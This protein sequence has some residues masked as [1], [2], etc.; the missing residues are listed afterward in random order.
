MG[1][2]K[3]NSVVKEL[4]ELSIWPDGLRA[5]PKKGLLN[6]K[7]K[8]KKIVYDPIFISMD[9]RHLR[10]IILHE[11]AHRKMPQYALPTVFSISTAL[12]FVTFVFNFI[13]PLVK[14]ALVLV[15]FLLMFKFF[16]KHLQQ[17]EYNADLWA[18]WHYRKYYGGKASPV[19]GRSLKE[20]EM[21][22][23]EHLEEN[24]LLKLKH[25]IKKK[26]IRLDIHPSIEERVGFVKKYLEE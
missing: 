17:D 4:K 12:F 16:K 15:L 23:D 26:V 3:I 7:S 9:K 25:T 21:I 24:K 20:I 8:H 6:F 22:R 5:K 2:E 10:M 14:S 11:L 19:L 18:S 13:G 1:D